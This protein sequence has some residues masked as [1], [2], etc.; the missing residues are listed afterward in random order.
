MLKVLF[1]FY[2]TLLYYFIYLFLGFVFNV[3]FAGQTFAVE[4]DYLPFDPATGVPKFVAAA[5]QI[6][7]ASYPFLFSSPCL[8]T[9]AITVF[10]LS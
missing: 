2:F 3:N 10:D 7:S 9:S 1:Y 5:I 6:L 8:F 4:L